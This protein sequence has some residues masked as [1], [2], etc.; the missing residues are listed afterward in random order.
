MEDNRVF[1]FK[2]NRYM[3]DQKQLYIAKNEAFI[4]CD[5]K[6]YFDFFHMILNAH[7]IDERKSYYGRSLSRAVEIHE[8]LFKELGFFV[9]Y[10]VDDSYDEEEYYARIWNREKSFHFYANIDRRVYDAQMRHF[11]HSEVS[12]IDEKKYLD[13]RSDKLSSLE[14]ELKTINAFRVPIQHSK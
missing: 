3:L 8:N 4:K 11:K 7:V 2:N 13:R 10:F 14:Y 1:E 5:D 6:E 12:K 9:E